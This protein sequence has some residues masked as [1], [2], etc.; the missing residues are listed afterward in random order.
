MDEIIGRIIEIENKACAV[1]EQAEKEKENIDETVKTEIEKMKSDIEKRASDK[2][3]HIKNIEDEDTRKQLEETRKITQE[4][5]CKL[6]E[7]YNQKHDE[8]VKSI[9]EEIIGL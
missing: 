2:C 4:A 3:A 7:I 9:T 5:K 8:W 6:E 1:V